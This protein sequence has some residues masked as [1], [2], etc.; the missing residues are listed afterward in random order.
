LTQRYRESLG[1]GVFDE[2][3]EDGNSPS[4]SISSKKWG[5]RDPVQDIEP[6]MPSLEK[7]PGKNSTGE[8]ITE[9]SGL[10]QVPDIDLDM[11]SIRGSPRK[12]TRKEEV[13]EDSGLDGDVKAQG[14][15][16]DDVP[17]ARPRLTVHD[18]AINVRGDLP[19]LPESSRRKRKELT[20]VSGF[21]GDHE[22]GGPSDEY[23]PARSHKQRRI[24][25]DFGLGEEL[26]QDHSPARTGLVNRRPDG[27][28][29]FIEDWVVD[30][31]F[32]L[33]KHKVSVERVAKRQE[34][35]PTQHIQDPNIPTA[36][37][38]TIDDHNEE[39]TQCI[40]EF[41]GDW[42]VLS[43]G[44]EDVVGDV[45]LA[46]R[47][48]TSSHITVD[49]HAHPCQPA[50]KTAIAHQLRDAEG[51]NECYIKAISSPIQPNPRRRTSELRQ[52]FDAG[53]AAVT[54]SADSSVLE[55][56]WNKGP[57]NCTIQLRDLEFIC[58]ERR[59][60]CKSKI[61]ILPAAES[62]NK[63]SWDEIGK[64]WQ[65]ELETYKQKH[66]RA[67]SVRGG[68]PGFEYWLRAGKDDEQD[69]AQHGAGPVGLLLLGLQQARKAGGLTVRRDADPAFEYCC[70]DVC[71][72][73]ANEDETVPFRR[74]FRDLIGDYFDHSIESDDE[75]GF[76]MDFHTL[77]MF[78]PQSKDSQDGIDDDEARDGKPSKA[79]TLLSEMVKKYLTSFEKII[80]SKKVNYSEDF[81]SFEDVKLFEDLS[82]DDQEEDQ[83]KEMRL[84]GGALPELH[85]EMGLDAN[86]IAAVEA[87]VKK[88]PRQDV[89]GDESE[90]NAQSEGSR[91]VKGNGLRKGNE[92]R[93]SRRHNKGKNGQ[94]K[95][96]RQVKGRTPREVN[97]HGENNGQVN[98]SKHSEG[99]GEN[100][101]DGQLKHSGQTNAGG[102][103][104]GNGQMKSNEQGES[105]RDSEAN[106]QNKGSEPE[107]G[108][109]RESQPAR[110]CGRLQAC[111]DLNSCWCDAMQEIEDS[112]LW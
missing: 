38:D 60:Q 59:G 76:L 7:G 58:F 41:M 34:M 19:S 23:F 87:F 74:P 111:E 6:D 84:R 31:D 17:T 65:A 100:N 88:Y 63:K 18:S 21:D 81:A 25:H 24:L 14:G 56:W 49:D 98:G 91:Q 20:D 44:V 35:I 79:F 107:N 82:D 64:A 5:Y 22:D 43:K 72:E 53:L 97:K 105:K 3:P 9:Y 80:L 90:G 71:N 55:S 37:Y 54:H 39:F 57:N 29:E 69:D 68:D 61:Q 28:E 46:E 16:G 52:V 92:P 13:N 99:N 110:T 15:D 73:E 11:P 96:N 102:Q 85:G 83:G 94:R 51:L 66:K 45:P 86:D 109:V 67:V 26:D 10:E 95:G 2:L 89:S 12:K 1:D 101:G 78:V 30:L 93:K 32:S 48:G 106:G 77:P 62:P 8:K 108:R 4:P 103:V 42:L 36:F 27:G 33:H 50:R 40:F 75:D 47:Q 70:P 104:E 112:T